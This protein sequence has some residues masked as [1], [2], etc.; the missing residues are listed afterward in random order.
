MRGG[1][2]DAINPTFGI[3]LLPLK[4]TPGVTFNQVPGLFQEHI[5]IQF[6]KQGQ[7]LL[8]APVASLPAS[9][10]PRLV[11]A[12][13]GPEEESLRS[14]ARMIGMA[15]RLHLAGFVDDVEFSPMD[16]T[17][18]DLER[19]LNMGVGFVAPQPPAQHQL[20]G[21][22]SCAAV[23]LLLTRIRERWH[24]Q[25]RL[26]DFAREMRLHP[27]RQSPPLRA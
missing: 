7:P 22:V 16:A 19:T 23:D 2:V 18:A 8:R 15:D 5:D 17:R 25:L 4:S 14:M 10:A 26:G 12:G 9:V 24:V 27:G 3:N 11:L 13:S 6:G 21:N 20:V 1:E